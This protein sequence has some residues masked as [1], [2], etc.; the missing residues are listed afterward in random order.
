MA[1]LDLTRT[2]VPLNIGVITL[3]DTRTLETDT[4]GQYLADALTEAGHV[5]AGRLLIKDDEDALK[6]ALL[7]WCND[8]AIQVILTTG[9]TG[10]THRDITPEVVL[11]LAD[12]PIPG[13]G[14]LFRTV[15]L[16]SVGTSTIQSR[17]TAALIRKTLVFAMPGSTGACRDGW[18]KIL[19]H[20]LDSRHR[21][22][23]F[24]ELMDRF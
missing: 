5:L 3:T 8:P 7:T 23:N 22:C 20:Q 19:V 15:S 21:P 9:G 18:S 12:K 1:G 10:I 13:F 17:A 2:F 6:T 11:A 4:S 14:E 24:A 16:D